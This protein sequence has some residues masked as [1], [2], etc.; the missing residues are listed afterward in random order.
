MQG[1]N[2]HICCFYVR[3][4]QAFLLDLLGALRAATGSTSPALYSLLAAVRHDAPRRYLFPMTESGSGESSE[5]EIFTKVRSC[6]P[7]DRLPRPTAPD[8]VC[9]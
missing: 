3:C 7:T 2:T 4:E 5:A 9:M 6:L 1:P 8:P